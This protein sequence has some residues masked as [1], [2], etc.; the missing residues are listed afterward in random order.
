MLGSR[1]G[2]TEVVKLL[3]AAG[4]DVRATDK[5][6]CFNCEKGTVACNF[7]AFAPLLLDSG[8]ERRSCALLRRGMQK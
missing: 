1:K 4:A 2:H 5:V 7:V 6:S 3:L 8:E